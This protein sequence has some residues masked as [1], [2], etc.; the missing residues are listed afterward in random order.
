MDEGVR[1]Q[2]GIRTLY[3]C[4][5]KP[6]CYYTPSV[7]NVDMCAFR[8]PT[9]SGAAMLQFLGFCDNWKF[10]QRFRCKGM[11]FLDFINLLLFLWSK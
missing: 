9:T 10:G 4:N 8:Y 1:T 11:I 3:K 7:H 2:G 5:T 6:G